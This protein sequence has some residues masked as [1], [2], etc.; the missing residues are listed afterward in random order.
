MGVRLE[1]KLLV[2]LS[3]VGGLGVS[4]YKAKSSAN[5][6]I[7]WDDGGVMAPDIAASVIWH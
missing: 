3:I 4:A 6:S 2:L 1:I 7:S 5:P